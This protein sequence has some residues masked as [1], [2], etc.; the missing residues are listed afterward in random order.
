MHTDTLCPTAQEE[1][2]ST[3][4]DHMPARKAPADDQKEPA[5]SLRKEPA[6]VQRDRASIRKDCAPGQRERGGEGAFSALTDVRVLAAAGMLCAVSIILGYFKV[7]LTELIELRFAVLPIAAAGFLYGP[8][9]AG[10]VGLVADLG[11]YLVKPTGPFFPGFT[12]TSVVSG[13][14]FGCILFRKKPSAQRILLAEILYTLVCCILLNSLWLT[15]LYGRGF[16]AVLTA[17]LAKELIMIP[18]NTAMLSALLQAVRRY[19]RS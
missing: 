6:S 9:C 18:V 19:A 11:G 13:I 2:A 16:L 3:Q 5:P 17:R 15:M 7:P 14:I 10:A 12:L 4:T 8:A 1:C